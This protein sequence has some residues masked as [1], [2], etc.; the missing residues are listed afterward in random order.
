MTSRRDFLRLSGLAAPALFHSSLAQG[1]GAQRAS[2]PSDLVVVIGAGLAGLY[3]ADLLRAAGR[4]V[5]VLEASARAG[6]RVFTYRAPLDE[7]LYG[8]AGPIRI[9]ASHRRVVQLAQRFKLTLIPFELPGGVSLSVVGGRRLRSSELR[10][11]DDAGLNLRADERPLDERALLER[12]VGDLPD[13]L[14]NPDAPGSSYAAWASYDRVT[15]PEWLASRGAS[16]DAV[17]LMT[18]GGDSNDLSALYVLRQFALLRRTGTFF[19]IRGGMDRLAT[20][21]AVAHREAIRYNAQV[22][23]IDRRPPMVRI[24]YRQAGRVQAVSASRVICAIPFTTLREVE[25]L[26]ALSAQK[27]R[28]VNELEYLPSTR[29]LLQTR[30][31][32]WSQGGLSGY[33][34]TDRSAEIWDCGYDLPGTQGILGATVAGAAG[35]S[36]LGMTSDAAVGFGRSVVA[37]AFPEIGRH[38]AKGIVHRWALEPWARGAFAVFRPRQ[39]SSLAPGLGAPEDRIHFAGEHTS[40]WSGWME[41]ALESGERAAREILSSG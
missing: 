31:R 14:G 26:P 2:D 32:F 13:A 4:P 3:A 12:Y 27:S 9:A 7:G 30:T 28:V 29:F 38:F 6:G 41:G 40:S 16:A 23:R 37:D 34:R 25:F 18:L 17:R 33:A 15:W 10:D 8:E 11:R 24:D 1:A 5:V 35:R 36:A 21:L 39:M 20:A 22:V 19:K